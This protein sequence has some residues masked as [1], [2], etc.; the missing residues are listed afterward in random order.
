MGDNCGI[1]PRLSLRLFCCYR[2]VLHDMSWSTC[3]INPRC[4]GR[5]SGDVTNQESIKP[6]QTKLSF[7]CL[8][9]RSVW[10]C[11]CLIWC[12]LSVFN[13]EAEMVSKQQ[14]V[15]IMC[16]HPC[17]RYLTGGDIHVLCVACLG[18]EHARAVLEGTGCEHCDVLPLRILRSAWRSLTARVLRL[19][20]PRALVPLL[21]R[22]S[23]GCSP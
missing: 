12:C 18:E 15:F 23:K 2:N 8:H 16:V 20:F 21:P 14:Q 11:P 5:Q 9:K 7:L 10:N 4:M 13:Y 3:E 1:S 17:P 19:A 6:A 22:H